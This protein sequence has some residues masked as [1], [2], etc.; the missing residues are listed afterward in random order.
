MEKTF[1]EIG[2]GR[3]LD[4]RICKQS[5]EDAGAQ[6]GADDEL[7]AKLTENWRFERLAAVDF[8]RPR[9]LRF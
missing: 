4:S 5:F 9:R 7:V 2:V 6:V 3:G 8:P 1:L